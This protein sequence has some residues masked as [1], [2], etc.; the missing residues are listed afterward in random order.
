MDPNKL[1]RMMGLV[2]PH[3]DTD[4]DTVLTIAG[5]LGLLHRPQFWVV[6]LK[7]LARRFRD[8]IYVFGNHEFYHNYYYSDPMAGLNSVKLPENVHILHNRV[9]EI[10]DIAFIGSTMWTDYSNDPL[11][12]WHANRNMMDFE[13]IRIPGESGPYTTRGTRVTAEMTAG[14]FINDKHFIFD[15]VDHYSQR[16]DKAWKKIVITHHG[17]SSLSVH[18]RYKGDLLNHAFYAELGNEI[19]E[20]NICLWHHGH[21]HECFDYTLGS[22]RVV[23]NPYGYHASDVNKKFI[24]ELVIDV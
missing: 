6:P 11:A 16:E 24:K 3:L 2:I 5:D 1:E 21:T 14:R 20:R 8:V 22:T 19:A 4:K 15:V 9:H 12:I 18:E 23:V 13:C 7:H 10:D 17:C